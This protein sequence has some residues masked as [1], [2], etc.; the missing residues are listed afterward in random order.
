MAIDFNANIPEGRGDTSSTDKQ[1]G[2]LNLL[3]QIGKL[4][5]TTKG[6]NAQGARGDDVI[7]VA[8]GNCGWRACYGPAPRVGSDIQDADRRLRRD[9]DRRELDLLEQGK[10]DRFLEEQRLARERAKANRNVRNSDPRCNMKWDTLPKFCQPQA[11]D[12]ILDQEPPPPRGTM[13]R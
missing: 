13:R 2:D 6:G 1:F 12:G 11:G 4:P 8:D 7:V 9:V 3:G 10:Y 5:G